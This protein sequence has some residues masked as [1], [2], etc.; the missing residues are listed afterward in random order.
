VCILC[1]SFFFVKTPL[2]PRQNLMNSY[3]L[4]K[5]GLDTFLLLYCNIGGFVCLCAYML[6]ISPKFSVFFV[7]GGSFTFLILCYIKVRF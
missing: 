1:S 4:E 7:F 6:L 2:I 5:S 3:R